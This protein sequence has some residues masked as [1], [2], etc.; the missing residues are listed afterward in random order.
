MPFCCLTFTLAAYS[1]EGLLT[2]LSMVC[3]VKPTL[4][5][6]L[7]PLIPPATCVLGSQRLQKQDPFLAGFNSTSELDQRIDLSPSQRG[8]SKTRGLPSPGRGEQSPTRARAL[9]TLPPGIWQSCMHELPCNGHSAVVLSGPFKNHITG[10]ILK[11]LSSPHSPPYFCLNG[12]IMK[13]FEKE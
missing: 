3:P 12:F 1:R 5:K 11:S 2:A 6:W 10:L 8:S 7:E 9:R 4:P 13:V